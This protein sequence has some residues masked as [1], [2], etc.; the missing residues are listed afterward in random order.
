[1]AQLNT[2]IPMQVRAPMLG[3]LAD[4][5]ILT[6]KLRQDQVAQQEE[7]I[8]KKKQLG[9]DEKR[10]GLAEKQDTREQ[11]VHDEEMTDLITKRK[12]AHRNRINQLLGEEAETLASLPSEKRSLYYSQYL[13]PSL[14]EAGFDTND[15]PE[16]SDELIH[17]WR[18]RALD[19]KDRSEER[20][21]TFK[22]A[23]MDRY[24]RVIDGKTGKYMYMPKYPGDPLA[25]EPIL[26]DYDAPPQIGF[27]Q[28][29]SGPYVF[30]SP[31]VIGGGATGSPIQGPGGKPVGKPLIQIPE[32]VKQD[33]RENVS[34]LSIV[35]TIEAQIAKLPNSPT[36]PLYGVLNKLPFGDKIVDIFDEKGAPSRQL[37]AQLSSLKMKDISGAVINA[38][39]FP[40]LKQWIP[41]ADDLKPIVL[42][43]LRN[44]ANE[45]I[46][47]NHEMSKQYTKEQGFK[48]DPLLKQPVPAA[49]VQKKTPM[50]EADLSKMTDEEL[51]AFVNGGN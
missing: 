30:N 39:E 37:I 12:D 50:T 4:S 24:D 14:T 16:Y 40:R 2:S 35:R 34:Q 38:H 23:N 17:G 20:K 44:F 48:E 21:S 3:D 10:I 43:K 32:N 31:K 5:F 51:D 33:I 29:D 9:L 45:V 47:I 42:M 22:N 27:G 25:P 36:N 26:T 1:M 18:M 13:L 46:K 19:P 28:G 8:I 6:Q 7:R 11:K 15:M 41:Q 49:P